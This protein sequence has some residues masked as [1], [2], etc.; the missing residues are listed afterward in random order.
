MD[1]KDLNYFEHYAKHTYYVVLAWKVI[2]EELWKRNMLTAEEFEKTSK[3]IAWHDQSK[4]DKDEWDPYKERFYGDKNDP[5]VRE[6]FKEAVKKHKAKSLHHYESL[7]E[8]KG[9]DWRCYIVELV[10]DYIAMGWEFGNYILEYYDSKR[11]EIDLPS[12]YK[13]YL[14]SIINMLREPEFFEIV[15]R[16]LTKERMSAL[17]WKD[18]ILI[19]K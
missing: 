18:I 6:S 9:P 16:P 17:Y 1:A 5:E 4:M 8:Y 2:C 14:E 3:H 19:Q 10:C 7:K 12:E 13:V 11:E 15:E